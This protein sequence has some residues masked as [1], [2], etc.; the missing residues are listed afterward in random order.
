MVHIKDRAPLHRWK[1]RALISTVSVSK[2]EILVFGQKDANPEA[3][4]L[5][6]EGDALVITDSFKSR[7]S[8]YAEGFQD[9][10]S[11]FANDL[12]TMTWVE[13]SRALLRLDL[14]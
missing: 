5:T 9:P 3:L 10:A 1:R 14:E 6:E 8:P 2:L 12:F 4:L 13:G 11:R 7:V